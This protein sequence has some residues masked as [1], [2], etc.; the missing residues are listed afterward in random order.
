MDQ[1]PLDDNRA[2]LIATPEKAL[3]DKIVAERGTGVRSLGELKVHLEENMRLDPDE[4]RK[5]D[6]DRLAKLADCMRSRKVKLLSR[7]VSRLGRRAL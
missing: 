7:L 4:L 5:L 6:P 3:A 2:F 1:V